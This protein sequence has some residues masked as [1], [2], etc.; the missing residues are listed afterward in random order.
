MCLLYYVGTPGFDGSE[1]GSAEKHMIWRT[2][3]DFSPTLAKFHEM[4]VFVESFVFLTCSNRKA[5]EA[6][7]AQI[8]HSWQLIWMLCRFW[9]FRS[10]MCNMQFQ[11]AERTEQESCNLIFGIHLTS[12]M[13]GNVCLDA[14]FEA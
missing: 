5:D 14:W 12:D 13:K 2:I 8:F 6:I 9:Y 10:K 11:A 3:P 4:L 7:R 1:T